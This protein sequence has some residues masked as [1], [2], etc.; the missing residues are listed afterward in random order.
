[1][2][3]KAG[4]IEYNFDGL[5]GPTH[6]YAGL[7][8][9]NV[10]SLTNAGSISSPKQAALQG[11]AK[12]RVLMDLGIPQ[13]VLP[14]QLRPNLELLR[15]LGFSGSAEKILQQAFKL[16]PRLL[17]ACY[18]AASMWAANAATVSPSCDTADHKL[19]I[20]PANL[21]Y[22]LHRA[23]ESE[24]NYKLFNKIFADPKHFVVHKPLLGT[25]DL[26][27]EGAANHSYIC[28]DYGQSGLELF[29]FGR[30]G[31]DDNA[32]QPIL[33]PARQ[34]KLASS[35]IAMQH[36]LNEMHTLM[37]QQNPAAI[38]AGV[39]HNDVVF[40]ANKNVLFFHATAFLQTQ[41]LKA[42]LDNLFGQEYFLIEVNSNE[43]AIN[44]AV[45]TY[46]FN[47]QLVS[48]PTSNEM[49]LILPKECE[50]SGVVNSYLKNLITKN[51]PIKQLH[52]VECRESMRNGGGPACLRLRVI[53]DA[54]EQ[55]AMHQGI[56]L[57]EQLYNSLVA[58]VN[59]HYREILKPEDL[60]DPH[61][62]NEV[63]Y[64]LEELTQLLKLG[65]I[66]AFQA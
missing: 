2:S 23:Q 13:A 26:S 60:L 43:I 30:Q 20:T 29:V 61:L 53:L 52:F 34:T 17:A 18:S 22:N 10:A 64:A 48:L 33:F 35:S 21:L 11:L 25:R 57:T 9:G 27:D 4:W 37:L 24:F 56:I 8:F 45:S 65:N 36:Q 14:P 41:E 46:V 32:L 16:Q 50:H 28:K 12:M 7:A 55:Q 39:F 6:N 54:A 47:S 44:E 66:Y 5:V 49:V 42:R 58:W 59:K 51:T 19:H 31:L 3:N 38:D 15:N 63:Q 62:A 40:V 1:M